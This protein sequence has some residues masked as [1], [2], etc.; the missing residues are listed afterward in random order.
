MK[1]EV[2]QKEKQFKPIKLVITIESI[3]EAKALIDMCLHNETIPEL[4]ANYNYITVQTF[5]NELSNI[6]HREI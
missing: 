2:E 1:V 5:L 3:E 4:V 6:L